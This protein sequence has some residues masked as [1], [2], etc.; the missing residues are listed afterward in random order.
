MDA[1]Q[2]FSRP[3]HLL[4][5]MFFSSSSFSRRGKEGFFD[6]RRI[7]KKDEKLVDR[8]GNSRRRYQFPRSTFKQILPASLLPLKVLL[9]VGMSSLRERRERNVVSIQ[10]SFFPTHVFELITIAHLLQTLI[11]FPRNTFEYFH[12]RLLSSLWIEAEV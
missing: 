11:Y 3:E 4:F 7:F 12:T 9:S 2:S 5:A 10:L 1:V 6:E 8:N